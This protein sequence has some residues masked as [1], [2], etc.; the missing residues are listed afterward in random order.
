MKKIDK[1]LIGL[2]KGEINYREHAL[3]ILITED[4][5]HVSEKDKE[6]WVIRHS[7]ALVYAREVLK[8]LKGN[9]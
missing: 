6:Q 9:R 3:S 5:E 2:V 8:Q 1:Y 4:I 7:A